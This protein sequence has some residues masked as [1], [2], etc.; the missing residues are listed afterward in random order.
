MFRGSITALVT[1]FA[2]GRR[3][4]TSLAR[5]IEWQIP[6]GLKQTCTLWHNR[7]EPDAFACGTQTRLE[8]TV[9]TA[10]KRIQV[11][12][13]AGSNNTLEAIDLSIHAEQAGADALL[14]V[15]PYYN[16]PSQGGIY[17]HFKA[18]DAAVGIQLLSTAFRRE[19]RLTSRLIRS[20]ASVATASM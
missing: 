7:G 13:G 1:P 3:R 15:A 10:K 12:A 6:G 9:E 17:Q 4:R 19:V 16:K 18:I 11:I 5:L 8:L 2:E 20:S 14:I